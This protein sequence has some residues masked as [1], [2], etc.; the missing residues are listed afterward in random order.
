MKVI[1]YGCFAVILTLLVWSLVSYLGL[2]TGFELFKS[3]DKTETKTTE[4]AS[5]DDALMEESNHM[6]FRGVPIDGSLDLFVKRMQRKGFDVV[7]KKGLSAVMRGDFADYTNCL[8]YVETLD[9]KDLVARIVVA[10]PVRDKWEYLHGDYKRLKDMLSQK[11]GK[12][13]QC[14]EKFQN[15]YSLPM[16]DGD[17]LQYVKMDRCKYESLFRSDKGEVVLKITQEN[18][19]CRVALA[20]KDKLNGEAVRRH[21]IEDL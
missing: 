11:Y 16:D 21:A 2:D 9:G 18:L 3:K 15:N 1:K 7:N 6:K 13:Y 17:K 19:D 20:Y 14:T 8:L 12:P 10:F 5:D 4:T